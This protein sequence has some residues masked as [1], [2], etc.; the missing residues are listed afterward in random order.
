MLTSADLLSPK[1]PL[2]GSLF[3]GEQ[4]NVLEGRLNEY[5]SAGYNDERVAAQPDSTRRDQLA[6]AYALNKAFT[7]VYIRLSANPLSIT[8]TEKGSHAYSSAQI[9]NFN[10]LATKYWSDFL[11]LL[12]IDSGERSTNLPGTVSVRNEVMW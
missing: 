4:S 1:G 11:G 5:L 8:E 2:D 3:P 12:A 10:K 7:Q 6:M 9:E